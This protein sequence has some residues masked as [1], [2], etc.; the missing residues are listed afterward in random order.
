LFH[1]APSPL[2]FNS[3][4]IKYID[5][6]DVRPTKE[7]PFEDGNHSISETSEQHPTPAGD[8]PENDIDSSTR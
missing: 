1:L 4:K 2:Y 7:I 3:L 5:I 8:I 6:Y